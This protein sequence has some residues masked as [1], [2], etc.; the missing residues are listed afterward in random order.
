MIFLLIFSVLFML[1][2]IHNLIIGDMYNAIV[3]I[4]VSIFLFVVYM[5]FK[6]EKKQSEKFL[7]WLM[8][9]KNEIYT[10]T[11]EYKGYSID[12]ETGITQFQFCL[13]FV[14]FSI[15]VPSRYFISEDMTAIPINIIYTLC[16]L[17]FG[18]WGLP[19]GPIYTI[20]VVFKNIFGGTKMTIKDII[21][22]KELNNT[23]PVF[24]DK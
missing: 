19:W 16:T 2:V 1:G 6:N 15:K 9:N 5:F 13:S 14:A 17:I 8:E 4:F 23:E 10:G 20:Q 11:A 12:E 22:S 18:W 7:K 21:P 24:K 3:G